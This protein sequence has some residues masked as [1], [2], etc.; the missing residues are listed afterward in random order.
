[1]KNTI[2]KHSYISGKIG[3]GGQHCPAVECNRHNWCSV[4]VTTCFPHHSFV[5]TLYY[6]QPGLTVKIINSATECICVYCMVFSKRNNH[7][8]FIVCEELLTFFL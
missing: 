8:Y 6:M 2:E 1:L 5:C 4:G 7:C 3:G